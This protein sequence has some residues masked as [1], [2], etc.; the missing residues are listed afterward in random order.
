[1]ENNL[2][3]NVPSLKRQNGFRALTLG[4]TEENVDHWLKYFSEDNLNVQREYMKKILEELNEE[5]EE[6]RP[7]QNTNN[8]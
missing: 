8:K 7:K 2:N 6:L 3:N 1:M 4:L 5:E